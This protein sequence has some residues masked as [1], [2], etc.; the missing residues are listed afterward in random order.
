M[1]PRRSPGRTIGLLAE[2][3]ETLGHMQLQARREMALRSAKVEAELASRSKSE[4]L[5]N[6]SHELRTP[7]NAIIGF[8]DLIQHLGGQNPDK[9]IEY[10]CHIADAGRHLLNIISDILDI[11]KIES[12]TATLSIAPHDLREL[13][14]SSLMLVRERMDEK[15]QRLE[16]RLGRDLPMLRV[17]GRRIKQILINLLSNAHKF[18]PPRG[19]IIVVARRMANDGAT[20]A[21]ADTGP[22]M[23]PDELVVALKPFGQVRADHLRSHGGTGLGLPIAVALARQHGGDLCLASDVGA[24]TTALLTLP[25]VPPDNA[26]VSSA[27]TRPAENLSRPPLSRVPSP[28]SVG[29]MA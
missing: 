27:L 7:L 26:I 28:V 22:G 2:Y 16:L 4:F 20:V 6:M 3:C 25:A 9:N 11:S 5:A 29:A 14:E 1:A 23:T 12:G 18:T 21:V 10:A 15:Q 13:I 8:S 24:G 19:R 17:D